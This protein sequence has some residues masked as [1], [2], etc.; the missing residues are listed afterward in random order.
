MNSFFEMLKKIYPNI[1]EDMQ[2]RYK[3]LHCIGLYEP[4]GRRTLAEA[5]GLTERVARREVEFLQDQGLLFVTSK[6][7]QL[8]KEGTLLLEQLANVLQDITGKSVLEKRIREMLHI[9]HVMI[10]SGNSDQDDWVKYEMGK[11]CVAYLKKIVQ[12]GFTLAVTGG[13]TM[14]AVA[15]A[16]TPFDD[17][18]RYLFVPARGGIGEKVESQ[19]NT[20][21]AEMAK[22]AHA[23]YRMLFVP[24]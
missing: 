20:I 9:D 10:I 12:P 2:Q 3:V 14:A 6:G 4:I 7:M 1:L 24:T 21:A 16:M 13:T 22:R 17:N 23:S 18:H 5:T 19:A 15:E 8:S 11:A